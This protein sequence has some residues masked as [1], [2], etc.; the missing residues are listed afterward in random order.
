MEIYDQ[1]Q[2]GRPVIAAR[3]TD[4]MGVSAPTV[5]NTVHRMQREVPAGEAQA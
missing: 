2:A 5:W 4:K 3:L 1:K